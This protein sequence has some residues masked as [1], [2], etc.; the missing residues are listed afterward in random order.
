MKRHLLSI[1]K[2]EFS[3]WEENKEMAIIN[4]GALHITLWEV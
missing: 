4:W 3:L 1:K 2:C